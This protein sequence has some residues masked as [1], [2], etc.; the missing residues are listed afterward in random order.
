MS[1][2]GTLVYM[3][4]TSGAAG[5]GIDWLD[6]SGSLTTLRAEPAQWGAPVFSPNGRL[7][8]LDMVTGS[9]GERHLWLYEWE[10]DAMTRLTVG[11][12]GNNT[13]AVWAPDGQSLAFMSDRAS[14][15]VRNIYW[16]RA[17][18]SGQGVALTDERL[19]HV[20]PVKWDHIALTGD[21]LWSEIERPR[22]RFRPLRTNRFDP[23]RF[24]FA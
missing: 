23:T 11:G 15:R 20:A 24:H 1:T 18:G 14:N 19:S 12:I 22:E 21:Y 13:R 5:S 9:S 17:D 3:P 4:S 8:A 7:L 2:N 6:R 16:Q 10:R